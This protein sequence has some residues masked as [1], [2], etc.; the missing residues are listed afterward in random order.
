MNRRE[1]LGSVG[2]FCLLPVFAGARAEVTPRQPQ[3]AFD[4]L[5]RLGAAQGGAGNHRWARVLGG[6]ISGS[7]L[8]GR[9]RGGRMDWHV[10]PASGAVAVAT[11]M[12]IRRA[13]GARVELRDRTAHAADELPE[14]PGLRTAPELFDAAGR[15]LLAPLSLAGRLDARDFARGTVSLRVY[16]SG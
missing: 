11:S 12:T 14:L 8:R 5:L 9:V 1:M 13:D 4:V 7:L 15:P 16:G 3:P 10:D 6:E 2:G